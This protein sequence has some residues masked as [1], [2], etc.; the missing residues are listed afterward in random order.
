[1]RSRDGARK[2]ENENTESALASVATSLANGGG[3]KTRVEAIS[4]RGRRTEKGT[5]GER[6]YGQ[7]PRDGFWRPYRPRSR[8]GSFSVPTERARE[9][10]NIKTIR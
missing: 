9:V 3:C 8:P 2:R 6:N 7:P 5:R 4:G 1:M 10:I